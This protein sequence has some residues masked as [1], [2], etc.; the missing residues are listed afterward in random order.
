MNF[1]QNANFSVSIKIDNLLLKPGICC[2]YKYII[3]KLGMFHVFYWT[4][5]PQIYK[6]QFTDYDI[7]DQ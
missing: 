3:K 2:N 5:M 4:A 7:I 1:L 6:P